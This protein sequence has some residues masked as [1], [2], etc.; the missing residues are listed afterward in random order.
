MCGTE[1]STCNKVSIDLRPGLLVHFFENCV[2]W[3]DSHEVGMVTHLTFK[4]MDTIRSNVVRMHPNKEGG[5]G[6]RCVGTRPRVLI[7]RMQAESRS[8]PGVSDDLSVMTARGFLQTNEL[9]FRYD[10]TK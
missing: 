3:H 10:R 4:V 7:Y 9:K 1:P 2:E 5:T 6:E 8:C